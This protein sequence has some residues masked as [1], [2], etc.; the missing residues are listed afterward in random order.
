VSTDQIAYT[1]DG[2]RFINVTNRCSLQCTF[3]PKL[4]GGVGAG[5][6]QWLLEREPSVEEMVAAA[7]NPREFRTIVFGG[8]GE[9][10]LRLY[11]VLEAARRIRQRGGVIRIDTDGLAN[12]VHGR[13]VT[14]DLEG[15]VDA[16]SVSLNAHNADVY[17]LHCRPQ[18]AGSYTTVLDFVERAAD[19]VPDITLTVID[20]LPDVDVEACRNLG[21]RLGARLRVLPYCHAS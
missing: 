6:R 2:R 10:T 8:L 17:E 4:H 9:P 19:Y 1:L 14:P 3:C 13:D 7:G 12:L 11:D 18:R 15:L 21:H 16:L 20:G 5:D